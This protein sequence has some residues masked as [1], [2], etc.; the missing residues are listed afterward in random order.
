L[1]LAASLPESLGELGPVGCSIDNNGA[2]AILNWASNA[3][4]LR[5]ICI[6]GNAMSQEMRERFTGLSKTSPNIA[7]YV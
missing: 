5:M 7:V 3:S 2:E 4:G 1:A 6:K